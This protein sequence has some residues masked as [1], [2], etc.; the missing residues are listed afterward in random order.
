M[1]RQ[2]SGV[3]FKS[4]FK[5]LLRSR[6]GKIGQLDNVQ[7]IAE[8]RRNVEKKSVGV[9]RS[10]MGCVSVELVIFELELV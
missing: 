1:N 9:C 10:R 7:Q 4:H 6:G 3:I 2:S 8:G 5:E